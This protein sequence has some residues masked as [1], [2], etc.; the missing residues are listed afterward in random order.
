MYLGKAERSA[1]RSRQL[2]LPATFCVCQDSDQKPE[3]SFFRGVWLIAIEPFSVTAFSKRLFE[4]D[5][6]GAKKGV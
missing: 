2:P 1:E 5:G 4:Q 6:N 3:N